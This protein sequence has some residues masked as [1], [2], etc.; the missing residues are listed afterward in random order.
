[1]TSIVP[2]EAPA[3][4]LAP[5]ASHYPFAHHYTRTL[6]HRLH[7]LDEGPRDARVLLL[8]H[9][10]PTWSFYYRHLVRGLSDDFRVI[11][12]DHLGCGLSDKP[13]DAP[14]TLEAH[15]ENLGRLAD[16]IGIRRATLIVHDWGGAIGMGLA[17]R[18]PELFDRFVVFNTAAFPSDR[19]P[20]AIGLCRI[21]GFGALAI[22]GWNAFARGALRTCVVDRRRVT[23]EVRR[24][25]LAPYD[26]WENR[27]ANLRFVQDIPMNADH[28]GYALLEEIG[29]RIEMFRDRPMMICWGGKDFVFDDG[30]YRE[31]KRRFPGAWAHYFIDAGHYVVEDAHERILPRIRVFLERGRS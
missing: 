21:P 19:M 14:Y 25:Y 7:Y 9:G 17:V 26:S 1:V 2:Y 18:R 5:F 10:N 15:I 29:E 24:G 27:V 30:F 8:L 12:P 20:F 13:Q 11:A 16:E 22:R 31:W 23:P 4:D 3:F 6:P 28:P